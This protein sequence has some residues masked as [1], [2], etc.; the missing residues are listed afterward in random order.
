MEGYLVLEDG[1]SFSG[2]L[3]GL[4]GCTGE[5]VFFT[6]MTGYQEVLTDPSYK[7]QII[8][9]TYPLIGNY[10]INES[11]DESKRPQVKG[12]VVYEAC[13]RFS[14]HQATESLREYLAKWD[15]P[16]LSHVDTRAVVQHI[17]AKGTLNARLTKQ[18]DG[19][20]APRSWKTM[21][22]RLPDKTKTAPLGKAIR[23]LR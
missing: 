22:H 18:K 9:F 16:L 12:V 10:G 5:V 1:T 23:I 11:D 2:E 3:D 4:D 14:H 13:D 20:P 19:I 7:G 8:V 21:R 17:R 15:V 6:G